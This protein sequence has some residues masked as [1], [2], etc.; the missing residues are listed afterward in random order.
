MAPLKPT[1]RQMRVIDLYRAGVSF[2]DIANRFS[3]KRSTAV[4]YYH[5]GCERYRLY[6]LHFTQNK[7][8]KTQK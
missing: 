7:N 2:D 6:L 4:A 3:I 5:T 1:N 8:A